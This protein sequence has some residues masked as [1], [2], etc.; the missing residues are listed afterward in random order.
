MRWAKLADRQK[1]KKI[2]MATDDANSVKVKNTG[3]LKSSVADM[4]TDDDT[5]STA[6]HCVPSQG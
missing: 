6:F 4:L 3:D 5:Y 1:K 2:Q